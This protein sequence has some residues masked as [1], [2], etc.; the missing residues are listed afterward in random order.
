MTGSDEMREG[1]G[2]AF[3]PGSREPDQQAVPALRASIPNADGG[4]EPDEV[5]WLRDM[6]GT[7]S[8][9]V[10]TPHCPGAIAYYRSDLVICFLGEQ[11]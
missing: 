3:G 9:H 10:C 2:I 8:M 5:V 11:V 6:D 4:E 1:A 7:G